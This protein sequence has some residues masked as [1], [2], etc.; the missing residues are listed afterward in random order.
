[1]RRT[2]AVLGA[3]GHEGWMVNHRGCGA[4]AGL[5]TRPYHSGRTE[6]LRAV[7]A[8]SRAQAPGLVHLVV[9]FSLSGNAA[10]LS[11]AQG[12]D[13]QPDGIVA[14]N[15]PVDLER[16]SV[17]IGR[18]LSRLYE[19]R[20][21]QRLRRAV[22]ARERNGHASRRYDIPR[23]TSLIEFDDLF[24]APECGFESGLD[25]YRKCSCGPRLAQVD[26]P[27]V[28][29]AAAD[30]PFVDPAGYEELV[31]GSRVQLH[32]EPVGGHMG[33]LARAGLGWRRWLD[34]AVA[35]YVEELARQS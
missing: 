32:L 14:V 19:L 33:Y 26:V 6:D 27:A 30:D 34:G 20:F 13:A 7:L 28:I 5:A 21:I 31:R 2:A 29:V 10:L 17:D 35:H 11:A 25:Y 18:G 15:P 24:T 8:A 23:S 22:A 12:L 9:G 1:M 4:G 3:R 16:T